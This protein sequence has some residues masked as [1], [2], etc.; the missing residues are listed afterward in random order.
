M[1]LNSLRRQFLKGA[2]IAA[3]AATLGIPFNQLTAAQALAAA[4]PDLKSY[5]PEYLTEDEMQLVCAI[6][7]RFI[8]A[9]DEGPGALE[10]NVPIFIDQ[11]LHGDYGH[12][13]YLE[14]PF[15]KK[16]DPLM[17]YQ[18]PYTPAQLYR[19][20]L[21]IISE[22]CLKT[23]NKPFTALNDAE[24]DSY[25]ADLEK[26]KVNFADFGEDYLTAAAFFN[27]ILSDTKNG[28]LADPIYGGNKGM[29][30]WIMI[31]FPGARASFLEWVTQHNVK[32][33]L[34]PVSLRGER[35]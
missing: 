10:S 14:G 22:H 2:A 5:K 6:C 11:Q 19:R 24:K 28:Y 8:P 25:L 34:G 3:T 32:Y 30:A 15:P 23:H 17:G 26:N 20:G 31:G 16:P 29:G 12:E 27:Q 1:S 9:D 18:M 13:W 4:A 33:P 35:A 7:D 21:K